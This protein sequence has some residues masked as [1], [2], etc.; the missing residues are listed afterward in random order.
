VKGDYVESWQPQPMSPAALETAR[1]IARAVTEAL[2]G[3][4]SSGSSCS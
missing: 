1:D 3:V 4:G 2:G